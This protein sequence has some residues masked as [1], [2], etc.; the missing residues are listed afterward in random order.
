MRYRF[1]ITAWVTAACAGSPPPSPPDAFTAHERAVIA[2]LAPGRLP[3]PGRDASNAFADDP[4]AARLGQRLFFEKAFSGRLL[5]ADNDGRPHTLGVKGETGKVACAGCHVPEA[6][7]LD[8]RSLQQ[9]I[10]LAAG[11]GRR[12]TPSLLDVGQARLLMWDG[13]RD[14]LYNQPFGALEASVEMNSSRL[15]MAEQIARLYR[16]DYQALFK[17]PLPDFADTARF[18]TLTPDQTGCHPAL[19][20]DSVTPC[21]GTTHGMPGDGA[22]YDHLSEA[23]QQAV[24]RVV[25]NAGKAL[26]AYERLLRCGEG[27]FDRWVAGT[28]TLSG[29]EQNGLKLFIGKAGCV[30]CHGGPFFTDQQFHDIGLQPSTVAVAFVDS[31]DQGSAAG[32]A[33][34][35]TDPLNVRGSFSDGDDGR[36][37]ASAPTSGAFRTPAL[38]CVAQRP[39]FMHTGQLRSLDDVVAFFDA[40]GDKAGFAGIN[41][42]VPLGLSASERADLVAFLG[43][44][45]GP[46]PSPELLVAP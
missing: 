40:G 18:P 8:N 43:T 42:L 10:S 41:E 23:D 26:A 35:L 34:A 30:S 16:D 15:F 21:N 6:G 28:G 20:G 19:G 38:R 7:F 12:R 5:D 33:A 13:R 31:G 17:Q 4:A 46:G 11:W 3:A 29:S 9:Q 25:V 1:A 14:A 37:L 27:R 45:T 44:L 24:T 22:E 39:T 32:L 36:L 2:T